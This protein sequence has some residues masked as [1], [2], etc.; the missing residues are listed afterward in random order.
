[1]TITDAART[2]KRFK[3]PHWDHFYTEAE[4]LDFLEAGDIVATDYI[5]EEPEL[6]RRLWLNSYGHI[7]VSTSDMSKEDWKLLTKADFEGMFE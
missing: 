3:R 1:M 4:V 6:K 5:I 2:N 7:V